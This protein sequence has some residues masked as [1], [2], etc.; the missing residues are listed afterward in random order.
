MT[1]ERI[2]ATA[3]IEASPDVVFGVLADPSL[4]ASI[5]GTGRVSEPVDPQPLTAVGQVFRMGMY[6]PDHPDGNYRTANQVRVFEPPRAI[7]WATGYHDDDGG[8]RFGG[9]IW[10]YDLAPL[11]ASRTTVTLTYDWSAVGEDVRSYLEFPPFPPE[12]LDRSL[13]HLAELV[14]AR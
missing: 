13:D 2:S 10:R 1:D 3:A 7:A 11:G 9:W 8:L 12:H 6:H 14:R 5:D 4:H